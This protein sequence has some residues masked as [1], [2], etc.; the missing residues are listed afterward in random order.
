M[1]GF[2]YKECEF[3]VISKEEMGMLKS[4]NDI[5]CDTYNLKPNMVKEIYEKIPKK[6]MLYMDDSK[7]VVFS[8]NGLIETYLNDDLIASITINIV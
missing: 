8:D 1:D 6:I 5:L 3:T 2:L 7:V 4:V